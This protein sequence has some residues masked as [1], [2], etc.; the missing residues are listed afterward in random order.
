MAAALAILYLGVCSTAIAT[1]IYFYLVPHLGAGR[2]QQVNFVV[3]A[4][5]TLFGVALLNEP[6][7]TKTL[8]ALALI[9]VAVY[10]VTSARRHSPTVSPT[11]TEPS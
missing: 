8:V 10:L 6:L 1:L 4:V 7:D 3:P 5:G 11:L 9:T 2:M